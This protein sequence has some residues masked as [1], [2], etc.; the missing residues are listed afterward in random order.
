MTQRI[1]IRTAMEAALTGLSGYTV[2]PFST[3]EIPAAVLPAIRLQFEP[4]QV[5]GRDTMGNTERRLDIVVAVVLKDKTDLMLAMDSA[6]ADVE[7]AISDPR[8]GGAALSCLLSNTNFL[9]DD[10][11]PLGEVRLTYTVTY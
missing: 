1:T 10:S 11:Q 8:L 2:M 9:P 6:T 5:V 7:S 3:E 4:E